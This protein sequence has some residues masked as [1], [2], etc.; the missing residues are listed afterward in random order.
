[1][2]WM[3]RVTLLGILLTAGFIGLSLYQFHAV[4]HYTTAPIMIASGT[5]TRAIL[6]QLHESGFTPHPLWMLPPVAL[7][8]FNG[9]PPLKAGEYEF[10][11]GL[12]AQQMLAKIRSGKV[13]VHKITIPEGLT[14]SQIR[15]LLLKEPA[16]SGEVDEAIAEGS[17]LPETYQFTRGDS[18]TSLIQR[19]REAQRAVLEEAWDDRAP[20]FPLASAYEALILASIVEKETRLPAERTVIAGVY[21]NRL[22]IGMPLQADPTVAYGVVITEK[23]GASTEPQNL[24]RADLARDTPFNTYLHTG[25]PPT[26]IACPGAAAIRATLHPEATDAIYFVATGSGGHA[27]ARTLAEHNTNVAAYRRAL[28]QESAR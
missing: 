17:L 22:R 20:D 2:K 25:L 13:V 1:M 21:L 18:R 10:E 4:R 5:G 19:M 23:N 7:E 27:F 3:I 24:T 15:A 26:P 8:S 11:A 6:N 16:L 14:T 9:A 12:N 28:R